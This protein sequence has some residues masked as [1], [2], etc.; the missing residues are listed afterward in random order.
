ME[1]KVIDTK[2]SSDN[3]SLYVK[4][5]N[6]FLGVCL[7]S[8]RNSDGK[9]YTACFKADE[10]FPNNGKLHEFRPWMSMGKKM[11]TFGVWSSTCKRKCTINISS[12]EVQNFSVFA[13]GSFRW[14]KSQPPEYCS[15]E[16]INKSIP[17]TRNCED[18]SILKIPTQ[19]KDGNMKSN[20]TAIT[21]G[22][23]ITTGTT[24]TPG[25]AVTTV[26]EAESETSYF[27]SRLLPTIIAPLMAGVVIVI[28]VAVAWRKLD[29]T[30][31]K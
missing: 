14:M 11:L 22:T 25:T 7:T 15:L 13:Y 4:P 30:S 20:T 6:N 3:S 2:H 29:L 24:I 1:V 26:S 10:C 18:R 5:E 21:T 27:H 19:S 16:H 23:I 9:N 28:L 31:C 17:F 8:P 12:R